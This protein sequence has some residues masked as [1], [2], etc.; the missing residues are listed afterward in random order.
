M[1]SSINYHEEFLRADTNHNGTIDEREFR[2]FLGPI[3]QVE[4]SRASQLTKEDLEA[5]NVKLN[6]IIIFHFI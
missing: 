4:K 6:P 1:N 5:F 2:S 3:K